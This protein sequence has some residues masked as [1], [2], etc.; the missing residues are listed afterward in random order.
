MSPG[1]QADAIYASFRAKMSDMRSLYAK[2]KNKKISIMLVILVDVKI[3][4][5]LTESSVCQQKRLC[6]LSSPWAGLR[7]LGT[8][9]LSHFARDGFQG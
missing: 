6:Q 1:V 9:C 2:Q 8:F 4:C 7:Q 3:I 5:V